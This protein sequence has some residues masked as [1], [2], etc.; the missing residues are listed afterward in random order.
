MA[1]QFKNVITEID[2]TGSVQ[3][4]LTCPAGKTILMPDNSANATLRIDDV[5]SL[6]PVVGDGVLFQNLNNGDVLPVLVDYILN[7]STTAA[8]FVVMRNET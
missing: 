6:L 3:P 5:R 4:L 8:D 2:T 7:T 1:A